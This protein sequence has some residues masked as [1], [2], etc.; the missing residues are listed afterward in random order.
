MCEGVCVC[1]G[2]MGA[3]AMGCSEGEGMMGW[4]TMVSR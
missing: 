3:G 1:A 2:V 4:I